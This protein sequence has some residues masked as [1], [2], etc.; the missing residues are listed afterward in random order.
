MVMEGPIVLDD[1]DPLGPRIHVIQLPIAGA[2][3]LAA[4]QVVVPIVHPP[5][6]RA[7]GANAALLASGRAGAPRQRGG[8]WSGQHPVGSG[9]GPAV[10]IGR[11][12]CRERV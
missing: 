6:Q 9:S 2:D 11:A 10:K 8:I 7:R 4:D 3:L 12:S 5:S 1:V